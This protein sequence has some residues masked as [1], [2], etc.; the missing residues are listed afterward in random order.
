[1]LSMPAPV[2]PS[3]EVRFTSLFNPGR[4]LTFPCDA[5]GLVDLDSLS[6]RARNNYYFARST[7]GCEHSLPRI[8]Q[9]GSP[10]MAP[11]H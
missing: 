5:Q 10:A 11:Q 7:V 2:T 8:C 4:A 9:P 6:E 1:M 3:F